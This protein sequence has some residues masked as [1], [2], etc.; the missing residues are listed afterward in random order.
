MPAGQAALANRASDR[1]SKSTQDEERFQQLENQ[2]Q[3]I[4]QLLMRRP[5]LDVEPMHGIDE[6]ARLGS[7]EAPHEQLEQTLVRP[8]AT[9]GSIAHYTPP[10]PTPEVLQHLAQVYENTIHLQPLSLFDP[11]QLDTRFPFYPDFLMH[12]FLS[13]ML[14]FTVHPHYGGRDLDAAGYYASLAQD[15]VMNESSRGLPKLEIVQSLCLLALRDMKLCQP[16]RVWMTIGTTTC[17][18]SLRDL[19]R[20]PKTALHNEFDEDLE[21]YWSVYTLERMFW[22][23]LANGL[24]LDKA[25]DYPLSPPI[26]SGLDEAV[27]TESDVA[28]AGIRRYCLEMVSIWGKLSTHLHEIRHGHVEAPWLS[29]STHSRLSVEL[30][31]YE[32]QLSSRHLMKNVVIQQQSLAELTDRQAY[33]RPWLMMQVISHA[34]PAI[35]NHPF[36]QLVVIRAKLNRPSSRLFLQQTVDLAL[37]HS[38]WVSRLISICDDM[39]FEIHNPLIGNVVAAT[40]TVPWFFQFVEDDATSS[41]ARADLQRCKG[42]LVRLSSTWPHLRCKLDVIEKLEKVADRLTQTPTNS[43]AGGATITFP[44]SLIWELLDPS[45]LEIAAYD[46]T[47]PGDRNGTCDDAVE[48]QMQ[49]TTHFTHPLEEAEAMH[50]VNDG[51]FGVMSEFA[52]HPGPGTDN[53]ELSI[54][55]LLMAFDGHR[56]QY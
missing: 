14:L 25:P 37:F 55:D 42:L 3:T 48:A 43:T 34:A 7:A 12:A 30:F 20:R 32:A 52:G 4:R 31:E 49:L 39:F 10:S 15:V 44:P 50:N 11:V 18:E 53:E 24:R 26:I 17:L 41:K 46:L 9:S 27:D 47:S 35:L 40:A 19:F 29:E 54:G 36:L 16:Y 1:A 45:I 5:G 22:R 6:V 51:S 38:G 21:C 13:L 2:V 23:P 33:W 28:D 8:R 56:F